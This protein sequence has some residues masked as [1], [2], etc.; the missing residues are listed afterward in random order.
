LG[1]PQAEVPFEDLQDPYGIEFWPEFKGR[2]GC[3]TPVPW[4]S[5][6]A[7]A[8]FSSVKPW[9]PVPSEHQALAVD[10]Q[11]KDPDSVLHFARQFLG[12]RKQHPALV[13][14]ALEL[15]TSA[16]PALGFQRVEDEERILCVFNLSNQEA[17]VPG[18]EGWR[19]LQGH[20]FSGARVGTNVSLPAFGAAF[21]GPE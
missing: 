5:K 3:R 13:H 11:E 6:L 4:Q 20:G 15:M 16:D 18:L 2:D 7:N 21:F 10:A 1:L 12:W 19:Q 9:L 14:G 17:S 8:G